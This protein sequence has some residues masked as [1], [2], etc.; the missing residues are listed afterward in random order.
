MKV[1]FDINVLMDVF[2]QRDQH[3]EASAKVVSLGVQKRLDA[4]IPGH[5]PTTI[6]YLITRFVG[7]DK[8]NECVDWLLASFQ[9]APATHEVYLRARRLAFSDFEDAVVAA[10]AESEHCE[11]I[12]TRNIM[13]FSQ[14][15]VRVM[16]P[17]QLLELVIASG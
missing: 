7:R 10:M 13:D 11:F 14:S 9:L 4:L 1:L 2:E 16:T 5:A 6:H 15:P 12:V 8:A 3:Y 17:A